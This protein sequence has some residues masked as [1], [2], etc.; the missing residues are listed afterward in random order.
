MGKRLGQH[1]LKDPSILDRIVE[2]LEPELHDIVLEVG[3]G[4]ADLTQRLA[5][6]VN[7]VNTIETDPLLL[8][9]LKSR[10]FKDNINIVAGDALK[11]DWHEVIHSRPFK[12]IGNIPYYI[13]SPLIEKALIAP[14]PSVIVFLMQAEVA[15]R[16]VAVPGSK[17]FGSISVGVRSVANVEKLF[18]VKP[19]AFVVPPKVDS[20]VVR[21]TPLE[22]PWVSEGERKDFRTFVNS[23]FSRRRKQI[24]G[25]IRDVSKKSTMVAETAL[26]KVGI[27]HAAR[28]ETLGI[29]QFV[30]LFRELRRVD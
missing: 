8:Q 2:G 10:D 28:P 13:T 21:F 20:A 30:E 16:L 14:R 5:Q 22:T 25:I 24:R 27:D 26:N 6:R 3:T 18:E 9:Q 4:E 1:F 12:V 19:G 11:I 29:P 17:T 23:L 7:E 15:D